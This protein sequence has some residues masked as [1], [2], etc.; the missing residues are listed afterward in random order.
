MDFTIGVICCWTSPLT[1]NVGLSSQHLHSYPTW[2]TI[3][4][5]SFFTLDQVSHTP[6]LKRPDVLV[7]SIPML[8]QMTRI[9]PLDIHLY[10]Q[11]RHIC[12]I[13]CP[14]I[15][16]YTRYTPYARAPD[17]H[18][19]VSTRVGSGTICNTRAPNRLGSNRMVDKPRTR[20]NFAYAFV[21]VSRK[22]VNLGV[23][24]HLAIGASSY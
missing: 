17:L 13:V 12:H 23:R 1:S 5:N 15:W 11:C 20:T 10:I 18:T 24:M 22:R 19:R 4:L 21:L 9:S 3:G 2:A 7:G 8:G 16:V 14:L 6:T